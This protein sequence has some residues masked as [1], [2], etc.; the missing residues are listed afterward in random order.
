MAK[1]GK[2]P[3][4][5]LCVR[6]ESTT[7]ICPFH[8]C[9]C[10]YTGPVFPPWALSLSLY[11]ELVVCQLV[12]PLGS[13][14]VLCPLKCSVLDPL[15]YLPFASSPLSPSLNVGHE[16]AVWCGTRFAFAFL[17]CKRYLCQLHD[18]MHSHTFSLL[19]QFALGL[20]EWQD[21]NV[22]KSGSRLDYTHTHTRVSQFQ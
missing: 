11:G 4:A 15:S 5:H 12:C 18:M 7:Q 20:A 22:I 21:I 1:V 6:A 17:H 19:N 10:V 13:T 9:P 2:R 3:F 14:C 8:P 16:H